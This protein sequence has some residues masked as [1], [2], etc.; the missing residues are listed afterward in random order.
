MDRCT[1]KGLG[2]NFKWMLVASILTFMSLLQIFFWT[3]T[4][5]EGQRYPFL[6][7]CLLMVVSQPVQTSMRKVF[8]GGWGGRA[9]S[10]P[11]YLVI[12]QEHCGAEF[13]S[14][15]LNYRWADFLTGFQP[16]LGLLQSR[17]CFLKKKSK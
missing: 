17:L 5:I 9:S 10:K 3:I 2:Q 4:P 8:F 1:L 15:P 16:K 11:T 12:S 7:V 6:S 13:A 14:Q